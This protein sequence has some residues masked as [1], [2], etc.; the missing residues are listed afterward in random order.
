MLTITLPIKHGI[1][2]NT[3]TTNAKNKNKWINKYV[4]SNSE[5]G[6]FHEYFEYFHEYFEYFHEYFEYVFELVV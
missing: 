5:I 3:A 6:A 4:I 2:W 1:A